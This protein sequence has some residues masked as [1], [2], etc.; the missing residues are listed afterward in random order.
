M[1]F[2]I[3]ENLRLM[4]DTVRRFVKKDLEP[5]SQQVEDEDRIPEEVVQTMRELGLFGL[6]IPEE[7]DGLGI[8]TLGEC[9]VYEELSAVN[10]CFRTRI[11]TNNGIGSQGIVIDGTTEQKE[12]YLPKLA[13]GEW[14]GVFALTEPEAG[15]DAANVQTTAELKGD[16]WVLNGRKHFITNGDIADVST[17]FAV[18]DKSKRAKGGITAFLV[19]KTDPGFFVGTIERKMG[20]RGSHTCELI[21]DN[22]EIPRDR[23]IGGDANLGLGFRTAMKTLD[24]GRLT[25]GAS[26]VG[27]AQKLLELSLDYAKQRVQFG[28]PICEFQAVQIMLADMATQIYAGRQMLHHAAWLRDK[29][30]TA[31][32]K[33]A[34][35]VKLFCTEMANRVADMAVQ[36]HGG[37]GYMKD[38]PV[39]R[40]YRD[41]RLTRIYEGTS[42]IQRNVIARELL[43]G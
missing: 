8:G 17:V 38:F 20:M 21:F 22:C 12:K 7:Y 13:S 41:L 14:I 42:E 28:K 43:K 4:T 16:K 19:E 30:G 25:M 23:I 29:R 40:F 26:A 2:E 9:L 37:M 15:S 32:I 34:S 11:G 31:V 10:A 6:S 36:I 3:P 18:T 24:K 5:I 35:M 39:E 33:E 1:D 27:S